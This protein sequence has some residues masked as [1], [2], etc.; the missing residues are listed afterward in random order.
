[1]EGARARVMYLLLFLLPCHRT[2]FFFYDGRDQQPIN[3][4]FTFASSFT[5]DTRPSCC[6]LFFS[7]SFLKYYNIVGFHSTCRV[8]ER[9]PGHVAF[10][11]S[12][13]EEEE[14]VV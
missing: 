14:A 12:K 6:V 5:S 9:A 13:D 7:I 1:M 4:L 8:N 2:F 11:S 3:F 10:K